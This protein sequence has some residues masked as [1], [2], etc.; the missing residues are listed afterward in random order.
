MNAQPAGDPQC[1]ATWTNRRRPAEVPA[2]SKCL[3][4]GVESIARDGTARHPT[5]IPQNRTSG[6][7][8]RLFAAISSA[9]SHGQ[10]LPS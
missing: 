3:G 1:S 6:P 10:E 5:P 2:R 7:L 9:P 8:S 4:N